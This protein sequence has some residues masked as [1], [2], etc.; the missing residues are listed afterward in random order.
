MNMGHLRYIVCVPL[1]TLCGCLGISDDSGQEPTTELE[2]EVYDSLDGME[3]RLRRLRS[4]DSD[5]EATEETLAELRR[6]HDELL[7]ELH[8]LMT[9]RDSTADSTEIALRQR[10]EGLAIRYETARLGRFEGRPS[11]E[12]AVEARFENLDRELAFLEADLVREDLSGQFEATVARLYRLRNEVALRIAE[13]TASSDR[14]FPELKSELAAVIG[15]LDIMIAH[16][17]LQVERAVDAKHP[18]RS[19]QKLWL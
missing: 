15:K 3:Y 5:D 1:L 13:A 4:T 11:F 14:E 10:L 12:E 9:S 18:I 16:S 17:T 19:L 6:H 2:Q 7:A 8:R